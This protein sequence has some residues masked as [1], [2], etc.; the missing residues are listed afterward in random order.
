MNR[1]DERTG[2]VTAFDE[3][4]GLG[5]VT[6]AAGDEFGFHCIE[7]ADGSRSIDVG[8]PV[9]FDVR[10]KLGRSEAFALRSVA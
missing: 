2:I 7:I 4:V 6:D 10:R 5:T 3:A 8:A 1:S 9:R